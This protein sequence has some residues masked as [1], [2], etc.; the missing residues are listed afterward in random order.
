MWVL[1]P[2][3]SPDVIA[4]LKPHARYPFDVVWAGEG[5]R[6]LVVECHE[7]LQRRFPDYELLAVKQKYGALAFQA[8]PRPGQ[9]TWT[10]DEYGAVL[11]ITDTY[12][13]RSEGV[14]EWCGAAGRLREWREV[15]ELTL[16][17]D[18]DA[19]FDDPPFPRPEGST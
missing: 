2:A 1:D 18:C 13:A 8:F 15:E 11:A 17:D 12:R 16:C 7:A 3:N 10:H 5:W 6:D 9:G 19:R 4:L 14:C